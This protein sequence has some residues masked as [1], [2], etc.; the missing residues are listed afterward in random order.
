MDDE[1]IRQREASKDEEE[2]T[3]ERSEGK[4]QQVEKVQSAQGR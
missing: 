3:E 2:I 4:K 1:L